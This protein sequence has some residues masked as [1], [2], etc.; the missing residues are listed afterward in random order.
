MEK[1]IWNFCLD[2]FLDFFP[3]ISSDKSP[4]SGKENVRFLVTLKICWTSGPDSDVQ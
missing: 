1:K 2:F 3:I 4:A